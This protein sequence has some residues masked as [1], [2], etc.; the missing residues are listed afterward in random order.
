MTPRRATA[1]SSRWRERTPRAALLGLF[2]VLLVSFDARAQQQPNADP[3]SLP[4]RQANFAWDTKDRPADKALLRASFS[5]RD[6]LVDPA[7]R[8]KLSNGTVTVIAMRAYVWEEGASAPVALAV[9]TCR[10]RYELW[11]E[12]YLIKSSGPGGELNTAAPGVDGVLRQCAEARDLA[13]VDR[14]VLKEAKRYY[15]AVIVEVNPV[16]EQMLQQMRQW[17]Q[18][19][20]GSTGIRP[21]DALFGSFVGLFVRQIGTSDKTLEFKTQSI[22]LP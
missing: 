11:D 13:I 9:R 4:A 21:G 14:S 12:V 1:P 2:A 7:L 17:V 8:A 22:A 20:A 3:S 5:Y 19:P 10:V 18:R 6:A 16:S 15:L